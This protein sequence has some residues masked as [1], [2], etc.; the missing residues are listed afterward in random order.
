[1][2]SLHIWKSI[3][4][5]ASKGAYAG[6]EK[7]VPIWEMSKR[8]LV[9]IALRLGELCADADGPY[10]IDNAIARVLDER[11]ILTEQGIL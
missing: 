1:M 7:T 11:R 5:A 8:E 10:T 3:E 6:S 9:E 4:K 2:P